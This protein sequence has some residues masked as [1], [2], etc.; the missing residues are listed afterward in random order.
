MDV[1]SKGFAYLGQNTV[2][3]YDTKTSKL[4]GEIPLG[5]EADPDELVPTAL[6][7]LSDRLSPY[8]TGA[9]FVVDG[10]IRLRSLSLLSPDA[11][12]ELN[13]GT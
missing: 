13:E 12:R 1:D 8:T 9:E 5:R 4:V 11:L 6:L 10:G 3:K 7:L 2:R